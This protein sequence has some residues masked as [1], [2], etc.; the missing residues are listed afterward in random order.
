[1]ARRV[2]IVNDPMQRGYRCEL[3][4][5]VGFRFGVHAGTDATAG[6]GEGMNLRRS[7]PSEPVLQDMRKRMAVKDAEREGQRFASASV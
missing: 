3:A 4:A 5:P 2:V 7:L 1:M 6:I